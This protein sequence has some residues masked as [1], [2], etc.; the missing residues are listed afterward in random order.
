M[1]IN[2]I[3]IEIGVGVC[4]SS[5]CG[6]DDIVVF[7]RDGKAFGPYE[8]GDGMEVPP[9]I[10]ATRHY[11]FGDRAVKVDDLIESERVLCG[12]SSSGYKRYSAL[13]CCVVSDDKLPESGSLVYASCNMSE[14]SMSLPRLV[15]LLTHVMEDCFSLGEEYAEIRRVGGP[16]VELFRGGLFVF[17]K[18][19][20]SESVDWTKNVLERLG[21]LVVSS[22]LV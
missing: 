21:C 7:S 11:R 17:A 22:D 14:I 10:V 12:V 18:F 9:C 3:E 8:G 13:S 1:K 6:G 2:G 16:D 4:C 19:R 20:C 5:K 15:G